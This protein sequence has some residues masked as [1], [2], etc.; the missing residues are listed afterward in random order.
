[1]SPTLTRRADSAC[2]TSNDF[3]GSTSWYEEVG[4]LEQEL[5]AAQGHQID[6]LSDQRQYEQSRERTPRPKRFQ[7][8][9]IRQSAHLEYKRVLTEAGLKLQ[10]G[11]HAATP[12]DTAAGSAR[13]RPASAAAGLSP[14]FQQ[15][16]AAA[17]ESRRAAWAGARPEQSVVSRGG[18]AAAWQE[19]SVP[20]PLLDPA[21]PLFAA[22]R[23][24][25]ER[26]V[27]LGRP[28]VDRAAAEA[29][30][31]RMEERRAARERRIA[32]ALRPQQAR[33]DRGRGLCCRVAVGT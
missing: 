2:Q 8:F 29:F 33:L 1:M 26:I 18:H 28:P 9:L 30:F 17:L 15:R 22:M 5:A 3:S 4:E 27:G 16:I 19:G 13:R 21:H 11:S 31:A 24:E 12:P 32:E 14:G 6:S 23:G 7:Q 25:R 20:T 10:H